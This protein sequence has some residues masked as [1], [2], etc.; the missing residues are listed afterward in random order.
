MCFAVGR[1]ATVRAA[2]VVLAVFGAVTAGGAPATARSLPRR[3]AALADIC[4][5]AWLGALKPP[6][7]GAPTP[8]LAAGAPGPFLAGAADFA[9]A[10]P[11]DAPPA[12]VGPTAAVRIA[13]G[14]AS[15]S[16]PGSAPSAGVDG[17]ADLAQQS[18]PTRPNDEF[19]SL[20]ADSLGLVLHAAD[21]WQT[22]YGRGDVTIAIVSD[23]VDAFDVA[24]EDD[25]AFDPAH[26]DLAGKLWRNPGEIAGNGRDDDGNGYVDDVHGWDF[27]GDAPFDVETPPP[28]T[29]GPG[30]AV[31]QPIAVGPQAV[32]RAF[33][34]GTQM[35][36]IAA[37]ETNNG[38]GIAG[39]SWGA[40]IMP[41]K[42][43]FPVHQDGQRI[44]NGYWIKHIIE[45][46][47]Y[48]ANH[49]AQVIVIGGLPLRDPARDQRSYQSITRLSEA[50][51]F[52]DNRGATVVVPAG[53]CGVVERA[54]QVCP[55]GANP[56]IF[57][58]RIN[59]PNV[60]G[61][62][63]MHVGRPGGR[64][65]FTRRRTMST[66]PWVDIAAP[67]EGFMT[68]V[69][70]ENN[71]DEPYQLV[72]V[73]QRVAMPDD[74]AA[75]HVAG[76][77]AVM[78]TVN[79]GLTPLQVLGYLCRNAHRDEAMGA[80]DVGGDGWLRNDV[81]GCGVV[82]F[83]QAIEHLPFR[84]RL[85]TGLVVHEFVPLDRSEVLRPFVNP[86]LNVDRWSIHTDTTW[87]A[88]VPLPQRVGAASMRA[89]KI[90][91]D[92]LDRWVGGLTSDTVIAPQEIRVCPKNEENPVWGLTFTA[93]DCGLGARNG[94]VCMQLRVSIA[95]TTRRAFLPLGL[96][97]ADLDLGAD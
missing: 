57:P 43:T 7:R 55:E 1:A 76:V 40:R 59:S 85:D 92:T 88:D 13:G 70:T 12:R 38:E 67:G 42:A 27:G 63:S 23:G 26:A 35:A 83:E 82:D 73:A 84:I 18:A 47:C 81:Y 33:N 56:D 64:E 9:A 29:T 46:V 94:C 39:V 52:A 30:D 62:T 53:E 34:R 15:R 14:A 19:L 10:G 44:N 95:G 41:L 21:A 61:V 45:G 32:V 24:G 37:A 65:T 72:D 49:G 48:A 77:I 89:L 16:A 91:V 80:F 6:G 90:N 36:G 28:Y 51:G 68:T 4:S 5:P 60:I 22:S 78:K 93:E 54:D 87:L 20:Q 86:Y 96:R 3:A 71:P 69:N 58:A 50:I 97:R 25:G 75:A 17:V 31:P 66:G 74:F 79:P 8:A 11:D 2:A